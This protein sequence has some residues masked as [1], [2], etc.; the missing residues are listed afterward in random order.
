[1][2]ATPATSLFQYTE[3]YAVTSRAASCA[4]DSIYIQAPPPSG[5]HQPAVV[6]KIEVMQRSIEPALRR[7]DVFLTLSADWDSEGASAIAP[8]SVAVARAIL[9][10]LSIRSMSFSARPV[11]PFHVAPMAHGGIFMEWRKSG[12]ALEST[13][14]PD[15]SVEL[16]FDHPSSSNRFHEKDGLSLQSVIKEVAQFVA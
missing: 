7:L 15:G 3:D 16:L 11:S 14:H 8:A 9:D 10:E 13:I 5:E 12:S 2:I 6:R 4:R 1:M